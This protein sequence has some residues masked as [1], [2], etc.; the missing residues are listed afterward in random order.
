MNFVFWK[1]MSL[2]ITFILPPY[3]MRIYDIKIN[4]RMIE[5]NY[6]FIDFQRIV[7]MEIT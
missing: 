6:G 7:L 2:G 1:I 4:D 5:T 3:P